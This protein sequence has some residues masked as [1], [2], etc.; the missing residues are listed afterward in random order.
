MK[1]DWLVEND[2]AKKAL[3]DLYFETG[4]LPNQQP[5]VKAKEAEK[6]QTAEQP[7]H[8]TAPAT[9]EP[10]ASALSGAAQTSDRPW[11]KRMVIVALALIVAFVAYREMPNFEMS[12]SKAAAKHTR[13]PLIREAMARKQADNASLQSGMNLPALGSLAIN[14]TVILARYQ[15]GQSTSQTLT[16]DNQ[17][18]NTLSFGIEAEDLVAVDGVLTL[19]PAG[20]TPN[21]VAAL[22]VFSQKFVQ[23]GPMEKATVQLTLTWPA[24]TNVRGVLARL[25]GTDEIRLGGTGTMTA[26]L[27]T[28][29]AFAGT[30]DSDSQVQG[31]AT[32]IALPLTHFVISQWS[33]TPAG[34]ASAGS[35]KEGKAVKVAGM[36]VSQ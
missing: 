11:T 4:S 3:H 6:P 1:H 2:V 5:K 18:P 19:V 13:S 23:V 7:T 12:P 9:V 24:S 17:T 36:G 14:P 21:S 25:R 26:T 20:D 35:P 31:A 32:G 30:Q 27:G 16:V 15:P 22:A 34:P 10:A 29:I 33:T 8:A 28:M